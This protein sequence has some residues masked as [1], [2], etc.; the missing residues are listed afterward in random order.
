MKRLTLLFGA[1]LAA[2]LCTL[3][4]ADA[5]AQPKPTKYN[6]CR[7]HPADG[8]YIVYDAEKEAI[9]DAADKGGC[10]IIG[11]CASSLLR[12][13]KNVLSVFIYADEADRVARIA[14]RNRLDEPQARAR[15][16][17]TDRMRR[18]YFDF[19]ADT[20]WGDPESYDVMLSSSYYGVDGCVEM[21]CKSLQMKGNSHE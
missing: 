14:S 4:A 3:P 20:Q 18:R 19:Y 2:A 21:I 6:L 5:A 9:L 10:V 8:P 16:R 15:M 1:L 12:D 17:K 11:R 13:R 7:K